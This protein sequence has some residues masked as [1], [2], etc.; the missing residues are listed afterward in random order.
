MTRHLP[1]SGK[2]A[3]F[4]VW[5]PDTPVV[6]NDASTVFHKHK[7]HPYQGR[8][9]Y[10]AVLATFVRGHQVFDGALARHARA[11]CGKP[12]LRVPSPV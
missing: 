4:V 8:Q 3:D 12:L 2:D 6:T 9:L 5:S 7:L 11:P 10:G 1:L